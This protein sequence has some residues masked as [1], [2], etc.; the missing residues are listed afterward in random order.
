[1]TKN[2][3]IEL[4]LPLLNGSEVAKFLTKNGTFKFE[5]FQHDVYY[6]APNR[7]F[8]ENSDNVN[9]WFRVRIANGKA[10]VNYK[11]WQPHESK[12]KTHCNEFETNVDSFEQLSE[13]LNALNFMK[14]IDVKKTRKAWD[15]MDA[16]VSID[17]VEGLGDFIEI[18][19]K[20]EI[21]NVEDAR[22]HLFK[23]L[24]KLAARTKELDIRGY[25]YLLLEKN[26][27]LQ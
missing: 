20:G 17:S 25:P 12:I 5:A 16:E 6:N 22:K 15:Y 2:I 9:E 7:N 19:Y 21:E 3:E 13:I 11:D 10:Q 27:L 23:I 14:L 24:K 1:M 8:L 26:A 18:E 4:K